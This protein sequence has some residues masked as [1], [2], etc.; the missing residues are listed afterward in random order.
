MNMKLKMNK[1]IFFVLVGIILMLN[2]I[3]VSSQ[4]IEGLTG[5]KVGQEFSNKIFKIGE[6][7]IIKEQTDIG[8]LIG[9]NENEIIGSGIEYRSLTEVNIDGGVMGSGGAILTFFDRDA[10][11]CFEEDCFENILPQ[12][13]SKHPTKIRLDENGDITQAD[14]TVNEKGGIYVFGNTQIYAPPDSRVFFDEITG[15]RMRVQD[16]A[17]LKE[18]PKSKTEG[19]PTGHVTIIET[20]LT[21]TEKY[22]LQDGTEGSYTFDKGIYKLP[23]GAVVLGKLGFEH[24]YAFAG[25]DY[26]IWGGSDGISI[27]NVIIDSN[28]KIDLYFDGQKRDTSANYLSFDFE[29]KKMFLSNSKSKTGS[30]IITFGENNPF[31]KIDDTDNVALRGYDYSEIE[32]INRDE[33]GLIPQVVTKGEVTINEN[34]HQLH[35]INGN[36]EFERNYGAIGQKAGET[37]SPIELVMYDSQGKPLFGGDKIV[38][39]NFKRVAF[40]VPKEAEDFTLLEEGVN[41]K[42][43]TRINYNYPTEENLRALTGKEII[44]K[45]L[46]K[47]EKDEALGFLRDQWD[48]LPQETKNGIKGIEILDNSE[49]RKDHWYMNLLPDTNINYLGGFA[50]PDGR[51]VMKPYE[52]ERIFRHE[53]AHQHHMNF[54][55]EYARQQWFSGIIPAIAEPLF[56]SSF[57]D[58]WR[59]VVGDDYGKLSTGSKISSYSQFGDIRYNEFKDIPFSKYKIQDKNYVNGPKHGVVHPYGGKNLFEDV[60]TFVESVA[61]EQSIFGKLINPESPK[62]DIRYR[63]KLDLLHK[64]EF[65]SDEEYSRVLVYSGVSQ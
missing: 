10:K 24:G 22:K 43:S 39:D 21:Q 49:F 33:E 47:A 6:A 32:I 37:T 48:A 51:I 41:K 55:R 38:F 56:S 25:G 16:G 29:N 45:G 2:L 40:F 50:H 53:A 65:I 34:Y 42:Y 9:L 8:K 26:K 30:N 64:Y 60:A 3:L 52:I 63:Q 54:N 28:N 15:I 35:Y 18:I 13:E 20:A 23:N 19:A 61:A 5:S 17:E 62:Y 11:A 58:E 1:K 46:S 27:N 14:F 44:L 4:E 59:E 12:D 36:L 57:E 31:V 7:Q